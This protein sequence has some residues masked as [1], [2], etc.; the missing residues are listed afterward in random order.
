M[1]GDGPDR[2][3]GDDG[4]GETGRGVG[5][6]G[7]RSARRVYLWG[8][9]GRRR[10]GSEAAPSCCGPW[11][12]LRQGRLAWACRL[13]ME[14]AASWARRRRRNFSLPS[15]WLRSLMTPW[16]CSSGASVVP[17]R[18][19]R[20]RREAPPPD[21]HTQYLIG[22]RYAVHVRISSAAPSRPPPSTSTVRLLYEQPPQPTPHPRGSAAAGVGCAA[23]P[24]PPWTQPPAPP[25]PNTG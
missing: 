14:V 13:L 20:C 25:H 23:H 12:S 4:E 24:W 5:K 9:R 2:P 1:V 10:G 17:A 6:E 21:L 22:G 18:Q 11:L 16:T 3:A 15:L 19:G 8:H 7:K